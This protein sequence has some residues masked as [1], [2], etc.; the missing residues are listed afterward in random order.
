MRILLVVPRQYTEERSR[1]SQRTRTL[2]GGLV[3][4]GH[5]VEILTGKWWTQSTNHHHHRW[6]THYAAGRSKLSTP[7]VVR[8]IRRRDPAVVHYV[9]VPPLILV[10]SAL[11][12]DAPILYEIR[13]FESPIFDSSLARRVDASIDRLIVP[14]EVIETELLSENITS[15]IETVP[16]PINMDLIPTVTPTTTSDIAWAS[17]SLD[18]A[19]LEELLL[20]LAELNNEEWSTTLVL[21]AGI[22][23]AVEEI[24]SYDLGDMIDVR[25]DTTRRERI[26]IY[27]GADVF[28]QTADAC[29][30]ATELLWALACGCIG[31]VQYQA[32]SGAHELIASHGHGIRVS[33]PDEIVDGIIEAKRRESSTFEPEFAAFDIEAI[34]DDLTAIYQRM[35]NRPG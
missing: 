30:F 15:D 7:R 27:R 33:T 23:E 16:D 17:S 8:Q 6:T 32:R 11:V 10:A 20:A 24:E 14:S 18:E 19:H 12:T 28:V 35:L 29:P 5:D 1:A 34:V 9:D 25:H 26:A 4:A 2:V 22:E 3:S 31:V 13:G 21:D